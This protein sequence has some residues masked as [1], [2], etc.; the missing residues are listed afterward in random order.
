MHMHLQM[1]MKTTPMIVMDSS[2]LYAVS[3]NHNL[4]AITS[5]SPQIPNPILHFKINEL[6]Q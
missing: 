5:Y 4:G 6:M 2:S 1:M 3:G